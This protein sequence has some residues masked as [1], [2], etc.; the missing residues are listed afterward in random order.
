[1]RILLAFFFVAT[2]VVGCSNESKQPNVSNIE[3]DLSVSRFEKDLFAIDTNQIE[4]G[5]EALI[6]KYPDFGRKFNSIILGMDT[7]WSND[8]AANYLK[9]FLS[10]Y[11]SVNDSVQ[12]VFS[13]FA[14]YEKKL[15][16]SVQY[17]RYYFPNYP[18]PKRIITYVGPL[19]GFGDI[20]DEGTIIVGLHL[21]LGKDFSLYKEDW[22]RQA[23]PDYIS[24]RFTPDYI[25]V[26][27][28][29]NIVLD[30]YPEVAEDK[31]L[32]VQMIEKGKRLMLLQQL[33]PFA[34]DYH[35]IGYTSKQYKECM[36]RE[37][38]IWDLFV[39]NGFLQ[40]IDNSIIKNYVG[41]GPKTQELGEASPG[42]IGSFC[43]WQIVKK[44]RQKYPDLSLDSIMKT[45]AELIF[46][47][48]KYK[49]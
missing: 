31:S 44:Y 34:A 33:V 19:D 7:R 14:P 21:H 22:V 41:E 12:Q 5:M 30:M 10:T 47:K 43:G 11:R 16:Q 15:E 9:G 46:E 3:A 35:I 23:Y 6:T 40:S 20:L 49:P 32:I 24:N 1:M 42:N 36:E 27:A 13:N 38:L 39:Q 45:D 4:V 29:K 2:V 8:T 48:T 25:T 18:A 26:N 17:L 28:M 37:A